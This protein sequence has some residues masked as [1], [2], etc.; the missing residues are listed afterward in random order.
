MSCGKVITKSEA[1]PK[2]Y[3]EKPVS[4]L[5]LPPINESTAAEAKEYYVTTIA[6]PLSL[7]GYYVYPI[8]I[9]TD[10]FFSEGM[11]DTELLD[12]S[13]IPKFK[14]YFDADAVLLIKILKWDTSY[15]VVGGSVT[16]KVIYK[17]I[18]TL[19]SETLWKYE[20]EI[21]VDTTGDSGDTGGLAGLLVKVVT[22]AVKTATTDY[23]PIAKKANVKALVSIPYGK[24]HNQFDKDREQK[25]VEEKLI[26]PEQDNKK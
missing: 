21:K 25:V 26:K 7:T 9:T 5:V 1:F 15:F 22:T 18:S 10:I 20:G 3:E 4:I 24:Y 11:Y 14:E 16:V 6:E 17:L 2:M 12:E 23:I 19:T 13:S 8:E